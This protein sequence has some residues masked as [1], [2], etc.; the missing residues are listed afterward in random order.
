MP[1]K[2]KTKPSKYV[3]CPIPRELYKEMVARADKGGYFRK[4]FAERVF[5]IGLKEEKK[6]L[7]GK[8]VD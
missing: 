5:K 7:V 6:Y 2:K 8:I 1:K 4:Y 3:K